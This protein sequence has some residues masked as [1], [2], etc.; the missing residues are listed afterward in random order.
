MISMKS[1][2]SAE[3]NAEIYNAGPALFKAIQRAVIEEA[4]SAKSQAEH[5]ANKAKLKK[6]VETVLADA[7]PAD[8][9][10]R[11]LW[12]VLWARIV[13]AGKR[14]SIATAE[15]SSMRNLVPLFRDLD[16]YT[17]QAYVFDEAEWKAFAASWK[18][19]QE[20]E[21]QKS[22]W[23]KLSKGAPDWN[24]AAHFANAKTT[25][26]VW[27]LLTKDDTAYPNLKF[28]T[29]VDKVRRYLAVADFLHRHRAAGKTQPLEH[30]T[31][32]RTLSRHHLT[33]E[34]WVQERKTLDE[35]RKRFEAQLGP[36]TALHTMMDL[37]L[38]TIKPDRVMAYLF[39]QLGWLQTLPASL[40]KEDVMAVYIRDEVTQEMTIRA[41]VLAASL[42]KAGYE[43][44]HRLL[45]IWFVK[46]GQDPEE[47][48]G[49]TTNLQQKS[50]SIRKV[51]DELDRS[52]PKHDTIT[53]DEARSM[54]PMQEFAA[55]AVRGATGGWKLPSGRQTKT[56]T[57]MPRVDAER[58]F[59]IEWQRG[60]SV[61]PDI[62]PAGKPG[63]ANG[64]KE[65]I[66][67]LIER[68]TDPE[69]AFLYVLVDEDE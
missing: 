16:H 12:Q 52:Q 67:S 24:P 58:L 45:D 59:T 30:Y 47:F 48:F 29:K 63:I 9:D 44:A 46:Y 39:S 32:G 54:W 26:E 41:D 40:S 1:R 65:E 53:V 19:R 38:N 28:S 61:R 18:E 21:A 31:D 7:I 2:A 27:K 23:I 36:L 64:P 15:I 57:K 55:V 51:F 43:Q 13:Y 42:D 69:E 14:A 49:I 66:L 50:K 25:P 11:G 62:Y 4:T 37:G 20:K 5:C 60:H 3:I 8:L 56:R 17:P 33:G 34:E 6:A 68:H 35:V 10:H 22:A